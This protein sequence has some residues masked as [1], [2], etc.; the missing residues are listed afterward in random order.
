[1][2]YPTAVSYAISHAISHYAIQHAISY[3]YRMR[4]RIRYRIVRYLQDI[5]LSHAISHAISH[6]DI[7]MRYFWNYIACDIACDIAYNAISHAIK[8]L[9][10]LSR[11]QMDQSF[12]AGYFPTFAGWG[13]FFAERGPLLPVNF[14]VYP[15][16]KTIWINPELHIAC[17]V[18]ILSRSAS[19]SSKFCNHT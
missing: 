4:Y 18:S 11:I 16:E 13:S 9:S 2:R 14:Q 5:F 7:A 19:C 6:C 12:F 8:K 10:H 15:S 3:G 1:M 17:T